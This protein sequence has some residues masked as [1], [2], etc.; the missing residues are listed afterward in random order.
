MNETHQ[1]DDDVE[2]KEDLSGIA[3]YSCVVVIETE[4]STVGMRNALIDGGCAEYEVESLYKIGATTFRLES[5]FTDSI[6]HVCNVL[7][8]LGLQYRGPTYDE[9]P[10]D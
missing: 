9:L 3:I 6:K 7:E 5:P 1:V 8:T 4:S 2:M 10:D